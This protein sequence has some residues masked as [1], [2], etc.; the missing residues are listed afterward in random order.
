MNETSDI[1]AYDSKQKYYRLYK[2]FKEDIESGVYEQSKKLPTEIEL[3]EQY[4][5]SRPTVAKALELL[6]KSGHIERV[7][8]AG[9]FVRY[10]PETD[11]KNFALLIPGL[12]ETEIFESICG[13]MSHLAQV[14]NFNLI[15]S[16]SMQEDA[17][18]RR[19]HIKQLAVRY[20]D[21]QHIDGVF[22]TPLELT[23]EKDSVNLNIVE[24][25]DK[26]G[27]PVVL[28]DRDIVS[29]PL[30]SK[31][32]IVGIDN[33]RL[34][35]ILTQ[36][37][38]QQGCKQVKFAARPHSAPTVQLRIFGYQQ[39]LKEA[40]MQSSSD[41]I[42]IGD[43]DS[44]EYIERLL[45]NA[46]QLGIVCANDTTASRLMHAVEDHGCNIPQ[47]VKVAGV[48]DIKYANYLRVPLTTYK[49]PCKD[50]AE[51]A[52]ELMFGRIRQPHQKARTVLL[53]G[54]LIVRKSTAGKSPSDSV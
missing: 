42:H 1:M 41:D 15:W 33:F 39:A 21:Q 51:E 23:S 49:Q 37:L 44:P 45:A 53:D 22:F 28:M 46:D 5:V 6:R 31:Y 13:H 54:E 11:I 3:A 38:L 7:S 25:F 29:F 16:G 27:I 52:I 26:A 18:M 12:G 48:D 50:I 9:T 43:I 34:A 19:Q 30:R 2:T 17:E 24:L 35:F 40:G 8:G 47:D 4:N 36:H 32:D 10:Q 20:I 14:K